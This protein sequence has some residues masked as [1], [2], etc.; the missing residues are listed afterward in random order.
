MRKE[1]K[2]KQEERMNGNEFENKIISILMVEVLG[3]P[4]EHLI[5]TL[6]E[7]FKKMGEEKGV[8]VKDFDIKEPTLV[9]DQKDLFTTFGEVE[10]TTNN[11]SALSILMF[12]YMP[13][14]IEIV[15]PEN[16]KISNNSLADVMSEITRRLHGYDEMARV[17]QAKEKMMQ[18]E[19]DKLKGEKK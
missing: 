15:E 18:N 8:E 16:L 7:I 17:M 3:R 10:V 5:E 1:K 13:S 2:K 4:K 14:H 9:K 6:K 11:F 12:K 19:I